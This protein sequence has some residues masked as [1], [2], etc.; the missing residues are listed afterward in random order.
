MKILFA[1]IAM[2]VLTACNAIGGLGKDIQGAAEYTSS[3]ISNTPPE[4][5]ANE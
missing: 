1:F 2:F 4:K 3:K 5:K